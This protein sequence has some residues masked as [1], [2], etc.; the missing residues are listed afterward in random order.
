MQPTEAIRLDKWL[1]QARLCKTRG[2]A[3]RLVA[4]GAV[5]VNSVRVTKPAAQ[6]H[7]GDGLTVAQGGLVRVLRVTGLGARR[8]PATEARDLY[9]EIPAAGVAPGT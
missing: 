7:V 1:W 4:S 3:A 2:I 5:R 9:A 6:L 8:G